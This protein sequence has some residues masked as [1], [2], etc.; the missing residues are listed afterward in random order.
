MT[1]HSIKY[2]KQTSIIHFK[3]SNKCVFEKVFRKILIE[4][5]EK[6]VKSVVNYIIHI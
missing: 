2:K 1:V 5:Y 3:I 4:N 6:M